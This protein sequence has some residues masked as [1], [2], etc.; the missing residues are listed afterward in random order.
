[1]KLS[2]IPRRSPDNAVR[3][4]DGAVFVMNPDTSDLHSFSEV[5]TRVWDLVDGQRSVAHIV[6]SIFAEYDV[7]RDSAEADVLEFLDELLTKGLVE[8]S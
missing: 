5:G 7:G 2:D 6:D 8:L 1:M 3:E 4:I